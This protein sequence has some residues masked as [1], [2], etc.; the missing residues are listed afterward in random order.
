[1]AI[2]NSAK[3]AKFVVR[4]YLPR[5]PNPLDLT[6]KNE[7]LNTNKR[8]WLVAK[9]KGQY[10]SAALLAIAETLPVINPILMKRQSQTDFFLIFAN[11]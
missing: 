11:S 6:F 7:K 10:L 8:L 3:S 9:P 5:T 4:A 2:S 1:M